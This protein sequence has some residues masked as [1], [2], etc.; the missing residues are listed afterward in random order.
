MCARLVVLVTMSA[1][2]SGNRMQA[3]EGASKLVRSWY[4]APVTMMGLL[5]YLF[6]IC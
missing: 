2:T 3:F 6:S 1:P 5:T 4:A